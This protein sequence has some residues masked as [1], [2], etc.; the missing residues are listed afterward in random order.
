MKRDLGDRRLRDASAAEVERVQRAFRQEEESVVLPTAAK[1]RM[2]D[3]DLRRLTGEES[4][5]SIACKVLLRVV[6]TPDEGV[7]ERVYYVRNGDGFK[8][9]VWAASLFGE[10]EGDTASSRIIDLS[11][12]PHVEGRAEGI[13]IRD[14]E[15]LKAWRDA[16]GYEFV[17]YAGDHRNPLA[18]TFKGKKIDGRT[19]SVLSGTRT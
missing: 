3:L 1:R 15:Y 9:A 10:W 5:N 4:P 13:T 11:R 18:F 8:A 17:R 16:Q 14:A 7:V 12:Y 6:Y 2:D 19:I